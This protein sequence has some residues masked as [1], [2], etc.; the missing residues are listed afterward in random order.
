[1]KVR[2]IKENWTGSSSKFNQSGFG[3]IIVWFDDGT[4]SSMSIKDTE[5]FLNG[6]KIWRDFKTACKNEE[7]QEED[8]FTFYEPRDY[9]TNFRGKNK[10]IIYEKLPKIGRWVV[11][12]QVSGKIA[13]QGAC[14]TCKICIRKT[15]PN[16]IFPVH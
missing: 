16:I 2:N 11:C 4:A 9:S 3:E 5:I 6:K 10:A 8:N 7:I 13:L 14:L 12:P 15:G 1:M